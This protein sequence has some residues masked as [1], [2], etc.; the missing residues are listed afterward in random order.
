MSH[1]FKA[2]LRKVS[3][4]VPWK[5]DS[6]KA[7]YYLTLDCHNFDGQQVKKE[8]EVTLINP[9]DSRIT[10]IQENIGMN[11]SFSNMKKDEYNGKIKYLPQKG[12]EIKL[13]RVN[14]GNQA[15]A[16]PQ[17]QNYPSVKTADK[18]LNTFDTFPDDSI[19][20]GTNLVNGPSIIKDVQVTVTRS[21]NYQSITLGLTYVPGSD[22]PTKKDYIKALNAQCESFLEQFPAQ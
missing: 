17:Q 20:E 11:L 2:R 19:G 1:E 5:D 10:F 9:F 21:K 15:Q 22:G 8:V 6:S 13:I 14:Q 3:N 12:S 7:N 4:R 16:A 18:L